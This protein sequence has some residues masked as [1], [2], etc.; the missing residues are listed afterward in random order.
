VKSTTTYINS[1]CCPLNILLHLGFLHEQERT[2]FQV[3]FILGSGLAQ[4][5][6]QGA[7]APSSERASPRWKL[8]C[9]FFVRFLAVMV[10]YQPY[11]NLLVER[12]SFPSED[13]FPSEIP[14]ATHV[15]LVRNKESPFAFLT[16][17]C[18]SFYIIWYTVIPCPFIHPFVHSF[19]HS[20]ISH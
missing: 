2:I 5:K 20:F 19:I 1:K 8:T 17:F 14:G 3:K 6:G 7:I 9:S 10:L 16:T 13:S 11:F 4:G 15:G 18:H 12:L